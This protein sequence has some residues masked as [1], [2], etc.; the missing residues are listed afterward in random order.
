M[1][2]IRGPISFY[3]MR[4]LLGAA[5]AGF[6]P[7]MILYM[8]RW[9]P[10]NARARAVAWFMTANPLAGSRRQPDLRRI[11]RPHWR[12]TVGLAMDVSD[13][14]P[15]GHSSS[16]SRFLDATPISPRSTLVEERRKEWLLARLALE[17]RPEAS[18]K[19]EISG[20][21]SSARGSGCSPWSTSGFPP[22]CTGSHYGSQR[23]PLAS[24]SL[25]YFWTGAIAVLPFVDHG[26]CNGSGRNSLRPLGERRW[27]T[28]IP[29]FTGPPVV[30]AAYGTSTVVVVTGL[31]LGHG[32]CRGDV[33]S[34]SG[35]WR[36]R[37]WSGSPRLQ[38]SRSSTRW[39]ISAATLVPTS[40][41]K[42][43]TLN[44]GFGVA[45]WR[46]ARLWP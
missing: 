7:G 42:F 22:P 34:R 14:G 24:R 38:E 28:A 33:R 27:H 29:A 10:A 35:P 15:P 3:A 20:K 19:K 41:G 11:A 45:C 26:C 13:R 46:S 9:F 30:I 39:P 5:E 21:S 2:F 36:P 43:R 17:Q 31:A 25:S 1:I 44:G 18:P 32:F 12:R 4:F 23:H 8:K 37:A 6:F 16:G 40:S